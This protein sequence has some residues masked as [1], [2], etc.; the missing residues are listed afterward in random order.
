VY[1]RDSANHRGTRKAQVAGDIS[2]RINRDIKDS[3][4]N[5]SENEAAQDGSAE[6]RKDDINVDEYCGHYCLC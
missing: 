6:E 1:G 2:P 5:S 3:K 4:V